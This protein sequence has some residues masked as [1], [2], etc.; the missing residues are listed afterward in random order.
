MGEEKCTT[1]CDYWIEERFL[2]LCSSSSKHTATFCVI[3]FRR[4]FVAG[5]KF[6]VYSLLS[7]HPKLYHDAVGRIF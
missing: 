2:C 5:K 3:A 4:I 7:N 6:T 1:R